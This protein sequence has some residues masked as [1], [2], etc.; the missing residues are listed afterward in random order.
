MRT[1]KKRKPL[2]CA[3]LRFDA[4]C[5]TTYAHWSDIYGCF[6]ED[7]RENLHIRMSRDVSFHG[8][9]NAVYVEDPRGHQIARILFGGRADVFVE[10]KGELADSF[11]RNLRERHQ[12]QVSRADVCIDTRMP[13][14]FRALLE[15][16]LR[17]KK[18]NPRTR[19]ER[20]GGWDDHPEDGRTFYLGS[21]SSVCQVCLYEKGKTRAYRGAGLEDWVRL[22]WRF[23]P[24]TKEQKLLAASLEPHEMFTMSTMAR[25]LAESVLTDY[26][27]TFRPEIP[28][29]KS[30][31]EKAFDYMMGQYSKTMWKMS[32][33]LG[34]VDL[35]LAEIG[36]R[37]TGRPWQAFDCSPPDE[38]APAYSNKGGQDRLKFDPLSWMKSIADDHRE[39]EEV[40]I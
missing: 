37:L 11:A 8:Y 30:A 23:R 38:E 28:A 25:R 10:V 3:N 19:S 13:G 21:K 18:M 32:E 24:E 34:G 17:V 27:G 15:Y 33:R 14:A 31:P 29:K 1:A 40:T 36:L 35:L 6:P 16:C 2:A 5:A 39:L 22:E 9:A 26:D 4:Y 12:H 7:A 20:R